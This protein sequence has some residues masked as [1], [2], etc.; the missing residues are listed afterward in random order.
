MLS[1][2]IELGV[3]YKIDYTYIIFIDKRRVVEEDFSKTKFLD[4]EV[5]LY[6]LL[7]SE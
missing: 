5:N 4:K 3:L 7:Y 2:L 6:N 1:A